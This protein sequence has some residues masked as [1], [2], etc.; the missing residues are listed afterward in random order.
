[1]KQREYWDSVSEKKEFT[2]PL[3]REAFAKYV[4]RTDVILDVGCGYGRTL[5]EL[6]QEGFRNLIGVD[7]ADGMIERGRQ[8]FPQLDLRV[9]EAEKID[10]PDNSV[11][12]VILFA[13]LTCIWKNEEQERLIGEIQRVLKADGVIY[14]NDYLLNN[15]D[16]N[17]P[18]YKKFSEKYGIY[19]VFELPEGAVCR[20]H[21]L[22]WVRTLLAGFEELEYEPLTFTTMNGNKSNGFYFI[23]KNVK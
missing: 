6:H 22:A 10:L 8:Q 23:G 2:T 16:H 20:H 14:V 17:L 13:V 11:D 21:D 19:G 9:K 12:A 1:M 4:K 18:R 5:N 7:F 15:D 3:Q